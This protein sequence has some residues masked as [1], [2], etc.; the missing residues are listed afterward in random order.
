MKKIFDIKTLVIAV[1][2][3]IILFLRLCTP[4]PPIKRE[5][6]KIDGKKYELIKHTIDTEYVTKTKTVYKP[7]KDIYVTDT[8]YVDVP[9]DVDTAAILRD[10]YAKRVYKDTFQLDDSLGTVSIS[11]TVHQNKLLGR[12]FYAS[13]NKTIIND[14]KIVKE[15]PKNQLYAGGEIGVDRITGI[16][17]FGP[18]I[19]LKTKTDKMFSLGA[20]IN[21]NRAITIQ[22][23]V[24]WKI[25]L[26]K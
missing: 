25:K 12:L 13:I 1:L 5:I 14:K 8:I 24:Y 7:G 6:I 20:G 21:N 22:G 9:K 11:D 3:I 18:N 19:V 10:Y 17:F 26:K 2:L 15:L 23:G 16:N 4:K